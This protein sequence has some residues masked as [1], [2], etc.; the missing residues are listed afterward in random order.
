MLTPFFTVSFQAFGRSLQKSCSSGSTTQ[1]RLLYS[2]RC[3][4]QQIQRDSSFP[5]LFPSQLQSSQLKQ[6]QPTMHS[7]HHELKASDSDTFNFPSPLFE[8]ASPFVFPLPAPSTRSI[9]TVQCRWATALL[10]RTISEGTL[11]PEKT[12]ST[13]TTVLHPPPPPLFSTPD[14]QLSGVNAVIF[15]VDSADR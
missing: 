6:A 12:G 10:M 11:P 15:I 8:T 2:A 5:T 1:A 14:Q 9:L 4:I 3:G 13:T 7:T